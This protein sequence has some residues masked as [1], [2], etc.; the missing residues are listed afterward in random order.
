M[1]LKELLKLM[2]EDEP[3]TVWT[4]KEEFTTNKTPCI[5]SKTV[6]DF[7]K[8]NKSKRYLNAKVILIYRDDCWDGICVDVE[9]I[10]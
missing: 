10:C 9:E 4:N 6:K 7:G 8:T 5:F 1:L 2:N 3:L